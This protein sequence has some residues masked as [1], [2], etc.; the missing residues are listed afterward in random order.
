VETNINYFWLIRKKVI[1][2]LNSN[3]LKIKIIIKNIVIRKERMK[4]NVL[5]HNYS[6]FKCNKFNYN[7][8]FLI[9][10]VK[11]KVFLIVVV[12]LKAVAVT[13]NATPSAVTGYT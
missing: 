8:Y 11:E 2:K 9:L 1:I 4:K 7:Y 13:R 5:A 6:I 3:H 10:I 12:S